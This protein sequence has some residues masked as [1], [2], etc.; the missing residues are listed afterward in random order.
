MNLWHRLISKSDSRRETW[1][2]RLNIIM[3]LLGGI[4]LPLYVWFGIRPMS[5]DLA[6]HLF[7]LVVIGW[8]GVALV[9]IGGGYTTVEQPQAEGLPLINRRE[10][11]SQRIQRERP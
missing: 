6:R 4:I 7:V 3:T 9:W 1:P 11:V 2:L 8:I 5:P 10:D